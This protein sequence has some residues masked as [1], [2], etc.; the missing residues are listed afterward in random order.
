MEMLDKGVR[1]T[2]PLRIT[3]VAPGSEAEWRGVQLHDIV[4]GIR[5][6]HDLDFRDVNAETDKSAGV[7]ALFLFFV[8][9]ERP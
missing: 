8:A 9:L 1:F 2:H 3:E 7:S 5:T 4:V 6:P